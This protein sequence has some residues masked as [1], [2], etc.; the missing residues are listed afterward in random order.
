MS[1]QHTPGRVGFDAASEAIKAGKATPR[2]LWV[3]LLNESDRDG[4]AY[5][6][7]P[8]E[9]AGQYQMVHFSDGR[10]CFVRLPSWDHLPEPAA[11]AKATG[12]P[13]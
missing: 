8:W 13:S 7:E 3:L 1:A 9:G 11:I 4:Y 12:S 6:P 2:H 10:K 5:K